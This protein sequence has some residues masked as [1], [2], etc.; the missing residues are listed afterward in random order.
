MVLAVDHIKKNPIIWLK[1]IGL[2][3][4]LCD[5]YM[6]GCQMTNDAAKN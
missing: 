6:R 2:G 5:D 4:D 1:N 3:K